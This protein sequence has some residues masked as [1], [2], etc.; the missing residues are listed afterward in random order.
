MALDILDPMPT[1]PT[2]RRYW[3]H[4]QR[5]KA[6]LESYKKQL[7]ALNGKTDSQSQQQ[8]A[9]LQSRIRSAERS[10]QTYTRLI[11]RYRNRSTP[12]IRGRVI[13][14]GAAPAVRRIQ[15]RV[16]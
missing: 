15:I 16:N 13:Q 9:L 11:N 3:Q 7:A 2:A 4:R 6:Q 5:M 10:I 14:R 8:R 12:N 1:N